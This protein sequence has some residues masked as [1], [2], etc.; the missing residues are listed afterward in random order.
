MLYE[1]KLAV[2]VAVPG[3]MQFERTKHKEANILVTFR[4]FH[5]T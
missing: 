4:F 2:A 1:K 5:A 3:G